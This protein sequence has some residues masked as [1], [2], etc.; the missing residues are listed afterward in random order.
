MTERDIIRDFYKDHPRREELISSALCRLDS[1]EPA[2]YVIG[3]WYFWKYTFKV[4]R[5]CLIPRPDTECLVETA[6]REIPKNSV[7]ADFCTGSGCIALS[8]LGERPDLRAV[9]YD[10]SD[11]ALEAARENAILLG[12]SDRISFLKCDLLSGGPTEDKHF[13]AIVSNPPYIRSKIIKDYPDLESEPLIALDGGEDGLVFYRRFVGNFSK[14]LTDNGK[15]IF[16]IGFDQRKDIIDIA[17]RGGFFC[18]VTKDYASNDR[19]ALLT[20]KLSDN[21]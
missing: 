6:I 9:G 13:G 15:F 10:I 4:N 20:K 1:G 8:I 5:D 17:E 21:A 16:E 19:V 18:T 2:A 3:E 14:N 12:F 7:F 11:G